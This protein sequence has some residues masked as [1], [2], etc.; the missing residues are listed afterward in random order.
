MCGRGGGWLAFFVPRE[1]GLRWF[2]WLYVVWGG[3][4]VVWG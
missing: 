3:V 1:T 4:Y 2:G